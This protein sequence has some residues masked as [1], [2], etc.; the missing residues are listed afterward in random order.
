MKEEED[1]DNTGA[2]VKNYPVTVSGLSM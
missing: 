2:N 1:D